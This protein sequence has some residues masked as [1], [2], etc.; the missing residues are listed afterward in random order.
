VRYSQTGARK[1]RGPGS[2]QNIES[3]PISETQGIGG[4]DLYLCIF[5]KPICRVVFWHRVKGSFQ[6]TTIAKFYT[7]FVFVLF[8]FKR[9]PD[10]L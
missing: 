2:V 3:S 5:P 9:D 6:G 1:G 8:D 10:L 4:V 7:F